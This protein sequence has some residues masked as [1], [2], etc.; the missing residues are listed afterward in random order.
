LNLYP[1]IKNRFFAT[2]VN[3]WQ[4][5]HK[6]EGK[7]TWQDVSF[8][9]P[10][11]A[12]LNGLY[13]EA[14]LT[15]PAKGNIVCAHPLKTAARGFYLKSGMADA[16]RHQGYNVLL[17]DFNGFGDSENLDFEWP[18]DI[19]A[20]GKKLKELSPL[21]P[22][23]LLGVSLGGSMGICACSDPD[24]DFDAMVTE[25]AFTSLEEF[26]VHFPTQYYVVK[27]MSFFVAE[28]RTRKLRAIYH[29]AQLTKLKGIL[30]IC[31]EHDRFSPPKMGFELQKVCNVPS[32]VWTVDGA[33]HAKCLDAEPKTYQDKVIGFFDQYL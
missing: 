15:T 1:W 28:K 11:N 4:W 10:T 30:F 24:H 6:Y 22:Q 27:L 12:R 19:L 7:E 20:A 18:G 5:P 32:E 33:D 26:W 16:L 9:S 23:G 29:A 31:G 2:P 3:Q 13:G 25:S 14:F 21:L 8:L 17:F